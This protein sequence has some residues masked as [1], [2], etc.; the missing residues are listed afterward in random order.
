MLLTFLQVIYI[1][2]CTCWR[3]HWLIF[4]SVYQDVWRTMFYSWRQPPITWQL[5]AHAWSTA[6]TILPASTSHG[7]HR[8]RYIILVL[9][10]T[11]RYTKLVTPLEL[12]ERINS[13]I[14]KKFILMNLDCNIFYVGQTS[15]NVSE[16]L[17][18]SL[19]IKSYSLNQNLLIGYLHL[20]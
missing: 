2:W 14:L 20:P 3:K 17:K 4:L 1:L 18:Y 7:I 11:Y 5:L 19:E 10:S 6:G 16:S 12:S 13:F 9:C 15:K 8:H